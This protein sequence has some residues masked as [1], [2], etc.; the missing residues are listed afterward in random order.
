MTLDMHLSEILN[1]AA[2]SH[3]VASDV[4]RAVRVD[5]RNVAVNAVRAGSVVV[6]MSVYSADQ[7]QVLEQLAEQLA[8]P[9][10]ILR[11]GSVPAPKSVGPPTGKYTRHAIAI[12]TIPEDVA[13][14]NRAGMH[15]QDGYSES[16]PSMK[17][18]SVKPPAHSMESIV[19]RVQ[20]VDW[21]EAW[22]EVMTARSSQPTSHHDPPGPQKS[23]KTSHS[24]GHDEQSPDGNS[25]KLPRK[26]AA[27][28]KTLSRQH[29]PAP[30]PRKA[31]KHS[32]ETD[33]EWIVLLDPDTLKPVRNRAEAEIRCLEGRTQHSTKPHRD[34]VP[35][36]TD[37]KIIDRGPNHGPVQ[38]R[39]GENVMQNKAAAQTRMAYTPG[40]NCQP[41]HVSHTEI[42][43]FGSDR[44]RVEQ[45]QSAHRDRHHHDRHH[46]QH[47]HHHHHGRRASAEHPAARQLVSK[48]DVD[49][50]LA[51]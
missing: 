10:S 11:K 41:K 50:G 26:D 2:F 24:T 32:K 25:A 12:R 37:R 17:S 30:G 27:R 45:L 31:T 43:V 33:R 13:N 15:S 16:E 14:R 39:S 7:L 51:F 9:Y 1:F 23:L 18:V 6:D 48:V 8:D 21:G 19:N 5:P 40:G 38:T 20:S 46:D 34:A 36:R 44:H 42:P 3:D 49:E 47:N 28:H 22:N 35:R 4:G 29:T